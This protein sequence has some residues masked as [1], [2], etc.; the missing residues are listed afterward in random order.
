[1]ESD[2]LK[3]KSTFLARLKWLSKVALIFQAFQLVV[4]INSTE[5]LTSE[6][7]EA[8]IRGSSECVDWELIGTCFWLHCDLTSCSVRTSPKVSHFLPDLVV[9]VQSEPARQAWR[10]MRTLLHRIQEQAIKTGLRIESSHPAGY[11]NVSANSSNSSRIAL[12]YF[13]SDVFG[14]PQPDVPLLDDFEFTCRAVTRPLR[15]YYQSAVDI[16]GWRNPSFDLI[17]PASSIPGRL[18]IGNWPLNSWGSIYPRTGWVKHTDLAMAAAV[19]AQRAAFIA[20]GNDALRPHTRVSTGRRTNQAPGRIDTNIA[21]KG[22]W[23]LVHPVIQENC[24]VFGTN[25]SPLRG[26]LREDHHLV[27]NL[28]RGYKCCRRAGQFFIED[29]EF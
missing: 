1:M 27:W 18:E 21:F 22:K 14:H 5:I 24:S 4:T 23:Q 16:I 15:P 19:V 9:T 13:E 3:Y 20:T 26:S 2:Q 11:G 12:R 17:R 29:V 7:V 25:Q 6:I 10:E 8:T 28:W